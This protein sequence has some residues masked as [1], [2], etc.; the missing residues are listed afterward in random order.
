CGRASPR[1]AAPAWSGDSGRGQPPARRPFQPAGASTWLHSRPWQSAALP[2]HE[3]LPG[4]SRRLSQ[5]F[6]PWGINKTN[7]QFIQEANSTLD[8]GLHN[9][10]AKA[11]RRSDKRRSMVPQRKI[12]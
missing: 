8:T 2:R 1:T 7:V 3:S 9:W 10:E 6:S 11:L 4:S 12:G 5:L